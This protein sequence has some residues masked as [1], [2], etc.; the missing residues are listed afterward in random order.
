MVPDWKNGDKNGL[1]S[2]LHNVKWDHKFDQQTANESLDSLQGE[3][4]KR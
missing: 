3:I 4:T 2:Y 1:Y